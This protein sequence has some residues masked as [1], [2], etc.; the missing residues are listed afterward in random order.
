[1]LRYTSSSPEETI[2]LG[3]R[4]G[5]GLKGG[6]LILFTGGLGSGKTTFSQGIA[7]ALGCA[8]SVSSPTFSIVNL[9][10]GPIPFAHFDAYRIQSPDDLETSGFYDYL[11]SGAVVAVEWS[12]NILTWLEPPWITVA[13]RQNT[14]AQREIEIEGADWL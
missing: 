12:E 14:G 9:Y 5:A 3:R 2:E 6:E 1:M 8:D 4:L 7:A 13:F 10:R 11:E